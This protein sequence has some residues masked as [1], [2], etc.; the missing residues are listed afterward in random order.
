M[1]NRILAPHIQ[2]PMGNY[3][4]ATFFGVANIQAFGNALQALVNQVP[5]DG[6]F[7]GDNLITYGR[8]LGFLDDARFMTSVNR[9]AET[10]MEQMIIWRTYVLCWAAKHGMEREGD[11][12]ECGCYKGTSSRI[13]AEY[14]GLASSSKHMYLYDLF[15]H[16]EGMNHH[17]M[18]EHS[19]DL[20]DKVRQRFADMPNVHVIQ[21]EIPKSFE[22]GMPEKIAF[23]HID[24]NNAAGELATLEH[25]YDRVQP[26][27][28]IV[29]DDYGWRGYRPQK[30]AEDDFFSRIDK[31]IL[32]IPT[33]QGILIK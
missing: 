17:A 22:Q 4:K 23:M 25:L 10:Q 24:M 29:F 27:A 21:G 2:I 31:Q 28:V 7:V 3:L 33:G 12:V 5:S 26:G 19:S 15:Y 6:L 30:L 20:A 16:E 13:V 9:H 11:F 32:E 1:V 8:N 18:P 14:A